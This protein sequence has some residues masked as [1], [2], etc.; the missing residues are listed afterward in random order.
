MSASSTEAPRLHHEHTAMG[1]ASPGGPKTLRMRYA[2]CI[3]LRDDWR[4]WALQD[5]NLGPMDYE[6]TALTAELRA[7]QQ[8]TGT[9]CFWCPVGCRSAIL[10]YWPL[11]QPHIPRISSLAREA[12]LSKR[13]LRQRSGAG[14]IWGW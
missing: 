7:L 11:P 1:I 5:L 2:E 9:L 3:A 8:L 13:L 6:S 4:W 14:G 10:T 12:L